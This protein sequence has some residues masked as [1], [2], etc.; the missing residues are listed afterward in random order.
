MSTFNLNALHISTQFFLLPKR[1][2]GAGGATIGYSVV[3]LGASEGA[4]TTFGSVGASVLGSFAGLMGASATFGSVGASV[5]GSFAGS[6]GVFRAFESFGGSTV[7]SVGL[8][9]IASTQIIEPVS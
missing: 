9:T 2:V 5:L 6:M 4:S 1:L 3:S 7:V 8:V